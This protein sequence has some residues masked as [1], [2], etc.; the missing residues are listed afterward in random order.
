MQAH[1]KVTLPSLDC[2]IAESSL[3]CTVGHLILSGIV[4]VDPGGSL[5]CG[6]LLD[7]LR[8]GWSSVFPNQGAFERLEKGKLDGEV[9]SR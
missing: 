5:V 1:E 4:C 8:S 6:R 9:S 3:Y 7:V 2:G